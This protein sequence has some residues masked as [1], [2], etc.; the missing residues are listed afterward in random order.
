[1]RNTASLRRTDPPALLRATLIALALLASGA[2][3]A[4]QSLPPALRDW[5]GWV[6]RGEEFRRCP[7][8]AS[9]PLTSGE[10]VAEHY[11]RCTWPERLA[12]AVDARGGTFTQRWQTYAETWVE[13]PG[14]REHWPRDVRLNGAAAPVVAVGESPRLL[15]PAGTHAVS[16]RFE[17]SVRPES[18][19]LPDNTAIVD[20]TVD[21]QRVAQPERPGNALW[22]GKRRSAEQ[23]AALEVQVY[24][25]LRDDIPAYLLT[26]IRLNVAGDAREELLA[27]A[28]PDGF[29]PLSLTGALPARL[30]RDG[31]LRVQVRAGSHEIL[32]E[33][34]AAG[35]ADELARPKAG[36]KWARDEIW[37]F[38]SNDLLRVAAAEGA[39]GIDPAQASVPPEW[40][41]LPA[42]RMTDDSKLRIVER[43]RGLANADDNQL[44]L[45]RNLWLDFDH[46]GFTAVDTIVGTL[47]RD[48]RL[49][50]H[51]PFTL[52]SGTLNG[53]Q[54]LV[55]DG[56]DGRAGLELRSPRLNLTT[57]ARKSGGGGAMPATG[58]DS[59][60]DHVSG[61]LHLP[62]GHRLLAAPG[63]DSAGG[64]WLENWGLWNVFGLVVVVVFVYWT[65]GIA[66]AVVAALAL[67]LTYQE[68]PGY[69]WLWGNLL[70]ALAIARSAPAGRFQ[71]FA[72]GYRTVSFVVLGLALLPFLWMQVRVALY[73]Q[74]ENELGFGPG[75]RGMLEA[76]WAA[77]PQFRLAEPSA[78]AAAE[79]A[80]PMIE[81][82]VVEELAASTDAAASA[83]PAP[84]PAREPA[85]VAGR[86]FSKASGLNSAQVVQRYAAGT[87]LQAGPGI[88]A[89]RYNFYPFSWS[90]PVEAADEVRF[91]YIG[92]VTL[93]F[94]R[95]AGVIGLATLLIWL[96]WLSFGN[97]WRRPDGGRVDA[98]PSAD[99]PT[100]PAE[101]SGGAGFA[102][103][104]APLACAA[105]LA[106]GVA[107]PPARAQEPSPPS[108]AL[109]EELKTRLTE[110]PRCAPT[111]VEI[112]N[113]RVAVDGER[114]DVTLE[115]S[116]LAQIA[117]A[118]PHA[119]DRWQLD[120][121]T[122]DARGTLAIAREADQ[123][124]WVPLT[125]GA[126][127]VRLTGRLAA[128]ESIPLA[129]PQPPRTISVSA[130]GWT[131]S[132]VNEGR[133]VAGSLELARV[134]ESRSGATLAAG[135]EFPA[136]VRVNRVFNLDLD[137]TLDTYV[138]RVAP[139]RAAISVEVPLVKGESVQTAGVETRDG[140]ALV[141]LAAGQAWMQWHSGLARSEAIELSLP[142][143]ATRGE[144][145]SFIV[146]PQWSVAFDGF[147]PVL[148][149]DVN[150]PV[151]EFRFMPR[152]GE[153]LTVRVTRPA[154]AR[155]TTLAID[156]AT[157][158]TEVG[159][160][161]S[162]VTLVFNYRSTQG[163]R[164]VITLPPEARVSSVTFDGQSQQLRPENGELP[165]SLRPGGHAVEVRWQ[166]PGDVGLRTR[167]GGV[168]LRSPASNITQ[169]VSMPESRWPLF[170]TGAGVGP[171]FLYWGELVVFI[172]VAWLLGGW[173]R[174]PLKFSEWL[175]LG[176]GL[177]TQ[178]WWV[179]ALTAAWLFVMRWR[180]GWQPPE[181]TRKWVFNGVQLLLAAFTMTVIATLVFSGIRNGLL[182]APDMGVTG[183][184]S[185][186]LNFR[187]F[188]DQSTG[189]LEPPTIWSVPMWVYR[190]LFF[191]WASWMAFALVRWLRTA[192]EAWKAGGLWR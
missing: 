127:T 185:G 107:A 101:S 98:T 135:S 4:Q 154:A 119:S 6:L 148:P 158:D 116:T 30:E 171:A 38:Q 124:L 132:G 81:A 164:H 65:A 100:M 175:L 24:R 104:L 93:F 88:P 52:A 177:S 166:L 182:V 73:P 130:R 14:D 61:R 94:W 97:R 12:L 37:S 162:T 86:L 15:L 26:R 13:L 156:N 7:F 43:S 167:P 121:V 34:R 99:A 144:V 82:D 91:I 53:E 10:P 109:L 96:A 138:A 188:Q 44:A 178:S 122:V 172:A 35:V 128:A 145:W 186:G 83:A 118:M 40:R 102:G 9:A 179:F 47:R 176:L 51:A 22:L 141:G 32:L 143:D 173:T 126:H 133:L 181:S 2:T 84:E 23:P 59:R 108:G 183:S 49:D 76:R 75:S 192:F 45:T 123:S 19:P 191:A 31:S 113:A 63:T 80:A 17:W 50:M 89:W 67:L 190:A 29:V 20:L 78:D 58:W 69:I 48:W 106:I 151:W 117:V 142:A 114:L 187:W 120:S 64:A 8:L 68:A 140:H 159:K 153:K 170:A 174:S 137:W 125:P 1:M 105:A 111:C 152:P 27:R 46:G 3:R 169:A 95:I 36:D 90:G 161:T 165:L 103:A 134:T 112:T 66:P 55:T 87:V 21:G 115:V 163:G 129:F 72:R 79:I 189:A 41:Q 147:P 56:K 62:P 136:Y 139:Q 60:F 25:L 160:R 168:D 70:A 150:A 146:N 42:F 28:L 54:L 85:I 184:N 71:R 149:Q 157:L 33:A 39:D 5:Q 74:L 77:S 155:G 180:A 18:L 110:A 16:G 57:V 131:V 11:Y 92:P